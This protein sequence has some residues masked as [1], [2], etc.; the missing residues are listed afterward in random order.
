MDFIGEIRTSGVKSTAEKIEYLASLYPENKVFY[1]VIPS[2]SFFINESLKTPFDYGKML[3]IMSSEIRSAE[4][5][6]LFKTLSLED[7]YITDPHFKQDK[8]SALINELG[9]K[10]GFSVD[11]NNYN[12]VKVENFIGQHKA[13]VQEIK[14]EEMYYLTSSFTEGSTVN[15]IMGDPGTTVYNPGKLTSASPYDL[16]LSGPSPVCVI[17]NPSGPEGKRLVIF[18]DSYSCTVAPMLLEAYS[19]ITLIDLRYVIST[20]IPN[21]AEIGNADI[22]FMYNEQIVNN[23]EMLKVIKK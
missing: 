23:G 14:G 3:E 12:K 19:E 4:Y 15:N 8:I 22:L 16:F 10:L 18:N 1:S 11:I 2:K 6:D 7:Y 9:S 21:Y 20:L 17:K 5:I 13:K